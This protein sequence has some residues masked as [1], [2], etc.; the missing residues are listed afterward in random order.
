MNA[1][2]LEYNENW[3]GEYVKDTTTPTG[4]KMSAQGH[5]W[6]FNEQQLAPQQ[7]YTQVQRNSCPSKL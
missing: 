4:W 5:P 7:H 2:I 1:L 6:V 3:Y